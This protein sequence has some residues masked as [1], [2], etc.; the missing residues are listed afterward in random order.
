MDDKEP[1]GRAAKQVGHVLDIEHSFITD[2]WGD[3]CTW[4]RCDVV[5][6]SARLVDTTN[7]MAYCELCFMHFSKESDAVVIVVR[8]EDGRLE[9]LAIR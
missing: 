8:H 4:V 2:D 3:K 6:G 9:R 1:L 5:G 7:H